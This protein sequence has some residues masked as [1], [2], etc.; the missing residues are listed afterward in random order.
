MKRRSFL[1][2]TTAAT[3]LPMLL[4]GFNLTAFGR[5]SMFANMLRA[6][7]ESNRVLV[8]I[9]LNGGND[10]LNTLIPVD[11]YDRLTP[12]RPDLII[13]ES[14]VLK[15]TDETALHPS[16]IAI[17]TLYQEEKIGI[18]QS[19]GYPNPNFSHFRATDIWETASASEEKLTSGWL[20]RYLDTIYPGFPDNYPNEDV[21]DPLAITIGSIVSNT[22]QGPVS[23]L[24]MA[25][26]DPE[27]FIQLLEGG[28]DDAPAT[29]YGHELTFLRQTMRQTNLYIDTI[30]AA[31]ARQQNLSNLY[32][33]S[34]RLANE[35][36]IVAQLIGGGLQTNIYVVNLGG[37]DTHANQVDP[38]D[39]TVGFH[40]T[41][42]Q[43]V[44]EA[45][46]AFQDDIEKMGVAD[47]V[48][49]MTFSE[50]GRRIQSNGSFGT[51]HG[52]AA[53]LFVFGN[54]VNPMIHGTN[55]EI[56]EVVEVKDSVPMQ[57]DFRSVYGSILMDWFDASEDLIKNVLFED[58]QYIPVL[59]SSSVDIEDE[60]KLSWGLQQ[61]YPNP[62]TAN[63][64]IRF[65]TKGGWVQLKVFNSMGQEIAKVAD[66]RFTAGTHE[67]LFEAHHLASGYY[68][69]RMQHDNQQMV[70]M[71]Q[72]R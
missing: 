69:Y 64:R 49:G 40:A 56:P 45:I 8:L 20:G 17:E 15:L 2:N 26:T 29:P 54:H 3:T 52:A 70:K 65:E 23:N 72:K 5:N 22:C 59:K 1:K 67:L 57:F 18:L 61:N 71:M 11:Q 42:L 9:Q 14:N 27:A 68:Y 4:G 48:L 55:P 51:D 36:K 34:N 53:P 6:A 33:D 13:P 38:T 41:L 47:R 16:M 62:F 39:S 12:V 66:R 10:G 37:F 19:V 31:A 46:M 7:Q 28:V 58:F 24:G 50:F 25:I 44:S 32:P 35:L 21:P 43:R 30:S 63:T 60:K